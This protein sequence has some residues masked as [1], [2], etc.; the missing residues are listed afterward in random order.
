M[1]AVVFAELFSAD[2]NRDLLFSVQVFPGDEVVSIVGEIELS[3]QTGTVA[4]FELSRTATEA[5]D[6]AD[7]IRGAAS[8]V[9]R[10]HDRLAALADDD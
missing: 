5:R 7:E 2:G 8:E 9:C 6:I 4:L 3:S 10:Q 1:F